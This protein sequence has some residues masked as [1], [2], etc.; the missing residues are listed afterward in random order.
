LSSRS[1]SPAPRPLARTRRL[2]SA[3][4]AIAALGLLK[5]A[6]AEPTILTYAPAQTRL[7]LI[8]AE[9][10]AQALGQQ[11]VPGT[12]ATSQPETDLLAYCSNGAVQRA[13][14]PKS[15]FEWFLSPV[16][17]IALNPLAV[18]VREELLRYSVVTT[19]TT[20]VDFYQGS[21]PGDRARHLKTRYR[22]LR[23]TRFVTN[24]AG[25]T[26]IGL[27]FVGGIGLDPAEDAIVL[28]PLR[29]FIDKAAAKSSNGRYGVALALRADAVWRE[30]FAGHR[31][32]IFEQTMAT[33][34]VDLRSGS[35]LKY[36][37]VDETRN[38]RVPIVPVSSGIDQARDFGR[39]D[40]TL[41]VAEFGA[42]P[43]IL[44]LLSE[45]FPPSDEG[46]A[47]LLLKAAL[48]VGGG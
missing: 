33:D 5:V 3:G 39:A 35:F 21:P 7:Q 36:Y 18:R 45:I 25:S 22:C 40:F 17:R 37:G 11:R 1:S 46:L 8:A 2:L 28:R 34:N 41:S 30:E 4:G 6:F 12:D 20:S 14:T 47:S 26:D 29:L 31:Q 44:A 10:A 15:F 16:L 43:A 32:S 13:A 48:A 27:D 9:D 42:P 24:A 19:G 38:Q 23:F